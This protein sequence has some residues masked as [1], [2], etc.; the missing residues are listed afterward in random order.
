M[1]FFAPQLPIYL[2]LEDY[3]WFEPN[4]HYYLMAHTIRQ[5]LEP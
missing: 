1:M 5:V 2:R 4:Q 3:S